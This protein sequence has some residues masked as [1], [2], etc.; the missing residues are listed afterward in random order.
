[1]R[2]IK[3]R[4]RWHCDFCSYTSSSVPG[5]ELHERRCWRNPNRVCDNCEGTGFVDAEPCYFCAQFDPSIGHPE[6]DHYDPR[7]LA[8][9]GGDPSL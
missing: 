7:D 1:M 5:M 3:V 6:P 2:P 4:P 8:I 9:L